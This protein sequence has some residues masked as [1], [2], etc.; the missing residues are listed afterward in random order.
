MLFGR[1]CRSF[2][3]LAFCFGLLCAGSPQ[4][5]ELRVGLNFTGSTFQV[6]SERIPPDTNG[7]VGPDHIVELIN[8]RYSVYSKADGSRLHTRSLNEFW[9][10]AGVVVR[11]R[12]GNPRVLYDPHDERWYSVSVDNP[13]LA[14]SALVAASISSNPLDGWRAIAVNVGLSELCFASFPSLGIDAESIVVVTQL[15]EVATNQFVSCPDNAVVL[16]PK[17]VLS[18]AVP[19]ARIALAREDLGKSYQAVVD[20]DQ[21]GMTR[22]ILHNGSVN[23]GG[24]QDEIFRSDIAGQFE[25]PVGEYDFLFFGLERRIPVSRSDPI[26]H[27]RQ[28]PPK[29][30][31]E[32]LH[33]NRYHSAMIKR[34]G[35]FWAVHTVHDLPTGDRPTLRWYQID[36]ESNV[37]LQDALIADDDKDL[38]YGSI[39]VNELGDVVVGFNASSDTEFI[40][41]YAV[42]GQTVEGVTTFGDPQLL[43]A[44]EAGY[45]VIRSADRNRWGQYSATVVDPVD[46]R[47]FWTFQEIVSA[48]DVWSTQITQLIV[49]EDSDG[50]G[51]AD[52]KDLCPGSDI[53]PTVVI[54]GCDTQVE[55]HVDGDGCTIGDLVLRCAADAG[56]HGQFVKCV[57]HLVDSGGGSDGVRGRG[58]MVRCAA[59][60]DLP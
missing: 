4:A 58:R 27:A 32:I 33:G 57:G 14:N 39:A 6:D 41:S 28:P 53:H 16:V 38:F 8:G 26:D 55:N 44:G 5:T 29:V 2:W 31:V 43:K 11:E 24:M 47:V 17:Q 23:E 18:A 60:S 50:D 34:N 42:L 7:A 19:T 54:D 46:H 40:S 12:A 30:D 20:L 9:M 48:E 10:D 25:L 56:N 35:S 59:R 37:V 1:S 13:G 36:A 15:K 3:I 21:D 22:T 51:V 49:F 52:E 45:E